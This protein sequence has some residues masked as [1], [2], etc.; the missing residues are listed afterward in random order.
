MSFK[1]HSYRP[2]TAEYRI[3]NGLSVTRVLKWKIFQW[4]PRKI[5]SLLYSARIQG[6]FSW[7]SKLAK[8]LK[9]F[10]NSFM[11]RFRVLLLSLSSGDPHPLAAELEGCEIFSWRFY[12]IRILGDYL[13]VMIFQDNDR[14]MDDDELVIWNW[15]TGSILLVRLDTFKNLGDS[16]ADRSV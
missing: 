3:S 15:K 7:M 13:G 14:E 1:S 12:D 2:S 16:R 8:Y 4:T 9:L 11:A 6:V 5:F 10:L